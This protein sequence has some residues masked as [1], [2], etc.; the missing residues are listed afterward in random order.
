M[1]LAKSC[2]RHFYGLWNAAG[3]KRKDM[4]KILRLMTRAG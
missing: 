3:A 1:K 2:V 4:Q